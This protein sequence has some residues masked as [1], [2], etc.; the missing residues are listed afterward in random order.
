MKGT[1]LISS[2]PQFPSFEIAHRA[3]GNKH[4]FEVAYGSSFNELYYEFTP[5]EFFESPDREELTL[6]FKRAGA[7]W[8]LSVLSA[9]SEGKRQFTT[10]QLVAFASKGNVDG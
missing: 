4:Y 8:M 3:E 6:Q 1:V 9:L 7:A 5:K 10:E 2:P